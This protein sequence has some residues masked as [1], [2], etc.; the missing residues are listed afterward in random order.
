MLNLI[1]LLVQIFNMRDKDDRLIAESM[2]LAPAKK[3]GAALGHSLNVADT[4]YQSLTVDKD[5]SQI[6]DEDIDD[7]VLAWIDEQNIP[8]GDLA[9][10]LSEHI[11]NELKRMRDAQTHDKD[12]SSTGDAYGR[13]DNELPFSR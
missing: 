13:S 10:G 7:L 12:V 8:A 11:A 2:Y 6:T 9:G 1:E 3:A 5:A 4:L